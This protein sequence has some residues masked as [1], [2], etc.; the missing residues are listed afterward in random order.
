MNYLGI[1]FGLRNIGFS[2]AD[3]PLAEP[4]GQKKYK[5]SKEL[6]EFI[7]AL[8][9]DKKIEIIVIG[10]PEGKMAKTIKK[11]GDN[12]AKT[13][14]LPVH[15]QDETLSTHEAKTKMIEANAPRKKRRLDHK[16]AATIIL[17]SY[18][19]DFSSH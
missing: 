19:D 13:I 9:S 14:S 4:L 2:F 11:F 15:Y 12:L 1:D 3:G 7:I 16:I 6:L 17:Q 10:L 8:V 5:T 18:L